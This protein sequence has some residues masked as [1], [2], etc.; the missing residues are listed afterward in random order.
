M[1]RVTTDSAD[2]LRAETLIFPHQFLND[3]HKLIYYHSKIIRT[4]D[5][6]KEKDYQ[7]NIHSHIDLMLSNMRNLSLCYDN[8]FIKTI[9]ISLIQNEY[10]TIFWIFLL[11]Q[12]IESFV[13]QNTRYAKEAFGEWK[14][15]LNMKSIHVF[16]HNWKALSLIML[17]IYIFIVI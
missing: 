5:I 4:K 12:F 11:S 1:L 14:W 16:I 7:Y 9:C 6:R 3:E 17:S 13:F 2:R 10:I 15:S 8:V